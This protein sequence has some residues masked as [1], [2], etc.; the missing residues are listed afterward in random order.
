MSP[1][2]IKLAV[3]AVGGQGG[4]VIADWI[5]ALAESNG[6]YAQA[7]S[8]PGVAQRTGA[9]IYYI[10]MT[11]ATARTPVLSLMPAPGDVD[12]VLA[13]EL[14]EAGRALQRGLVTPGRT[15]LIASSHRIHA[16]SEKSVPGD[17]LARPDA[18]IA[19]ARKHA[20]RF[21]FA[22]LETIAQR[23]GSV[24]SASLF[25]ALAGAQVLPFSTESFETAIRSHGKGVIQSLAAFRE[26]LAAITQDETPAGRKERERPAHT[27]LSNFPP[28]IHDMLQA[29]LAKIIDYQDKAYGAEYLERITHFLQWD[30][31]ARHYLLSREAAKYLANAMCYDDIIRVADLKTR[32]R[33]FTRIENES[34]GEIHQITEYMHPRGAEIC[35]LMPRRLGL[36]IQSRPRI[37]NTLD[38]LVN[39]GRHVK[40]TS[41]FWFTLLY[42]LAGL[43]R[44]RRGLLR[45]AVETQSITAWIGEAERLAPA[46]YDLAVE[47]LRCRRLIKGYSDTHARGTSKFDRVMQALPLLQSRGDAASWMR[48]LR[49]AAL[50]DEDGAELDGALATLRTL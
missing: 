44:V 8:V 5:V 37:F 9:T 10:E 26:G 42:G 4:G 6:W 32:A 27:D 36:A 14:M 50:K 31:A 17:G 1:R 16:V 49:E 18:V 47:V 29:G 12:I 41:L 30:D 38:R 20:A 46:N 19:A 28:A 21:L 24:I 23:H 34:G 40:T 13:S 22:D 43:R 7:T 25:G 35:S 11:P 33:R 48:R 2:I 15:T 45:H 39:R 3:L